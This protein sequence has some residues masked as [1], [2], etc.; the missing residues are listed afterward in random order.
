MLTVM[1]ASFFARARL[2]PKSVL[3][4]GLLVVVTGAFVVGMVIGEQRSARSAVPAGEGQVENQGEVPSYISE[5]VD[6]HEFWDVWNLL[7]ET[8]YR[9]PLSDK[10]L[11]YGALRGLVG[12][13]EDPYTVFFDPKETKDFTESLEGSF[14]GIGA[15]IGVKE[16]QLQVVAPLP[17]TPAERAGLKPGDAILRIDG[18]DT[19]GMAVDEAVSLIRGP[20]GT[21]VV[22]TILSASAKEPKDVSITREKIVI[23]S[24]RFEIGEDGIAVISLYFFNQEADGLFQQVVNEVLAKNA[25]GIILDLR[26]N[27]GG[28]LDVGIDI[29]STWIGDKPVVIEKSPSDS[30]TFSGTTEPRLKEISTVVLVNGGSASA[31]EI[32]AGALQD[33]GLAK[34]VGTQTFGKGSVQ[35][36]RELP[37]GSAVKITVAEWLTPNGRSIQD[38]GITPDVVVEV[39]PADADAKRDA[40]KEKARELLRATI[41]AQ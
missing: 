25:K 27:P 17:N 7:K 9:Q 39:I 26:S 32:L 33:Y 5:D 31:S 22:L 4:V 2:V 10:E 6:F 13:T 28:L 36:Y 38:T 23:E 30:R 40:Q 24:V 20:R 18:K 11:Y 29:A 1:F 12:S 41:L 19:T 3:V 37:D 15:E 16:D 14:D 21:K 34:I 8:Y 35:D